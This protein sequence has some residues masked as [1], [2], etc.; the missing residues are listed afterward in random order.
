MSSKFLDDGSGDTDLSVLTDGT[1]SVN[2]ES[3]TAQ[4][5]IPSFALKTNADRKIVSAKL[6]S[7]DL[8]AMTS[9]DYTEAAA[10]SDPAS[11]DLRLY[12]KTNGRL[13]YRDNV[14][15]ETEIATGGSSSDTYAFSTLLAGAPATGTYRTDNATPA[16]I[17]ELVIHQTNSLGA[18]QRPLFLT[19]QSGD[20][21]YT[22]NADS[23]NCKLYTLTGTP[24]DNTTYFTCPVT[25]NNQNNAA[26]YTN[27]QLIDLRFLPQVSTLQQAYDASGVPQITTSDSGGIMTFK[28]GTTG[29]VD[30]VVLAITDDVDAT[31]FAVTASGHVLNTII[32]QQHSTGILTGGVLSIGSTSLLFNVTAGTG[33]IVDP[34]GTYVHVEWDA[35]VDQT[36]ASLAPG[37]DTTSNLYF[38]A[39]PGIKRQLLNPSN[40]QKRDAIY[41]GGLAHPDTVNILVASTIGNPV[42]MPANS[43]EDFSTA[44]GVINVN[45]NKVS[46]PS[47]LTLLKTNGEVFSYGANWGSNVKNPH[48]KATPV[49]DSSGAGSFVIGYRNSG[50]ADELDI[51]N[52]SATSVIPGQYDDGTGSATPGSVAVNE[53][54]NM[55]V[56]V[57]IG[58][59]TFVMPGQ[60]IYTSL[61]QALAAISLEDF[62]VPTQLLSGA[63][64]LAVVTVSGSESTLGSATARI[65]QLQKFGSSGSGSSVSTMQNTY[66]NSS[67]PQITTT[68]A[69]GAV[70]YKN[71]DADDT[72][73]QL[74]VLNNATSA[75][76]F[77]VTAD[78]KVDTIDGNILPSYSEASTGVIEGGYLTLAGA[79]GTSPN[80]NISAGKGLITNKTT[81][82]VSEVSWAAQTPVIPLPTYNGILTWVHIDINGDLTYS[83]NP[84]SDADDR[85][86]IDI[87]VLVHTGS[88]PTN[89][90][91]VNNEQSVVTFPANQLRDLMNALGFINIE[92]NLPFSPGGVKI[93]KS[94]GKI[95]AHGS[96]HVN[97]E[98][99][100][101]R[102]T[103][104]AIDTTVGTGINVFQYRFQDGT[105]SVL[106]LTD[107]DFNLRDTGTFPGG[108]IGNQK[109]GLAYVFSFT[110]NALKIQPTQGEYNSLEL[111][112]ADIGSASFTIEPSIKANGLLIGYIVHRGGGTDLT[113]PA[114]AIFLAAGKF[115]TGTGGGVL[116]GTQNL[117]STYDNSPT[118]PQITVNDTNLALVLANGQTLDTSTV[119]EVKN[120]ATTTTF[121]VDGEGDIT[122]KSIRTSDIGL[123]LGFKAGEQFDTYNNE[124]ISIGSFAGQATGV[125]VNEYAINIGTNAGQFNAQNSSISIG[126]N[127][128]N[129][130]AGEFSIALG[131]DASARSDY[132]I[133]IGFGADTSSFT[134]SLALGYLASPS[135]NREFKIGSNQV[136]TTFNEIVPGLNNATDLGSASFKFKDAHLAGAISSDS[137]DAVSYKENGVDAKLVNVSTGLSTSENFI[138]SNE[139]TAGQTLSATSS[140]NIL[141]GRETGSSITSDNGNVLIGRA[142]GNLLAGGGCTFVGF[143]AGKNMTNGVNTAYGNSSQ[144]G[145]LGGVSTGQ[146]N[147]SFGQRSLQLITTGGDNCA[148]GKDA[149]N[150]NNTG[151]DN[152]AF[153]RD[154]LSTNTTGITNCAFGNSSLSTNTTGITNCAFGYQSLLNLESGNYNSAFGNFAGNSLTTGSNNLFLGA[155]SNTGSV[156]SEYCIALGYGS[157]IN[158]GINNQLKIG[159]PVLSSTITQILPGVDNE[160]S[161]GSATK[162]FKNIYVENIIPAPGGGGGLTNDN[163]AVNGNEGS[164]TSSLIGVSNR[165]YAIKF[166]PEHDITVTS[167]GVF[168]T[169]GGVTETVNIGIYNASNSLLQSATT[170]ALSAGFTGIKTVAITSQLLT[171]GTEYIFAIQGSGTVTQFGI[172][173]TITAS[174]CALQQDPGA[175][176]PGTLAG[177]AITQAIKGWI[178]A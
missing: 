130:D 115:G 29:G 4:N 13:Y 99:D 51:L 39:T 118:Q 26:N 67:S 62:V 123:A 121:S 149:L 132:G 24:V 134:H 137:I 111:A 148:F 125:G 152:C 157:Q 3:L 101:H 23:T 45:G 53:W 47:L 35:I 160:C 19:L 108:T 68:A 162:R 54:T 167:V 64:A 85:S 161:L 83:D 129:T 49:M 90:D 20:E 141:I 107:F 96:N 33:I 150:D 18:D 114:D 176:L 113:D 60:T 25:L 12:A 43:I 75:S 63:I 133:A 100:P 142:C 77:S 92:G 131:T 106:T 154:S 5:L 136:S 84:P 169:S 10:P 87:G 7:G 97:D 112:E 76:V 9:M 66:D 11:G 15:L 105:S 110:S 46:S 1:F 71:G 147:T 59:T 94:E 89:L 58:G 91:A 55:H 57:S 56:L 103:L 145:V 36:L 78:G 14:G 40:Q 17:T 120:I 143:N 37:A 102:L 144:L 173:S 74:E 109:W 175:G 170:S 86:E 21:I 124:N 174:S 38:D 139:A 156:D 69:L 82:V 30:D 122:A 32:G 70:Q 140:N 171:G 52:P 8:N 127:A 153:G 44:V 126:T 119:L 41:I 155:Q 88:P 165:V 117:Q 95:L 138:I 73:T 16:I 172:S 177:A 61:G 116:G 128:S 65:T 163:M 27:T 159:S 28:Q 2:A 166:I 158:A 31:N 81:G 168:V 48:L 178:Y 93:A 164:I 6:D 72:L 50:N 104:A 79:V 34:D 98:L 151:D 22:C 146:N 42:L 135:A 80:F